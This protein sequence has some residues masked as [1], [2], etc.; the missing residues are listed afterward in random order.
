MCNNSFGGLLF[1]YIVIT[2]S[3]GKIIEFTKPIIV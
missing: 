1:L 2:K 3:S